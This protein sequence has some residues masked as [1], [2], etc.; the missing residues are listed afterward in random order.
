[1]Q[2][3][4]TGSNIPLTTCDHSEIAIKGAFGIKIIKAEIIRIEV[5]KT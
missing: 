5:Y 1:M 2:I 4:T 3:S